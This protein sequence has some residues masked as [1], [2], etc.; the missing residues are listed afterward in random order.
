MTKGKPFLNSPKKKV[1][2]KIEN[3]DI[4]SVKPAKRISYGEFKRFANMNEF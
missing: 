1:Q 3:P 4:Y 2:N